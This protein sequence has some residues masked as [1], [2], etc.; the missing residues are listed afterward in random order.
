M[1]MIDVYEFFGEEM[2][3]IGGVGGMGGMRFNI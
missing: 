1:N 3:D 2:G